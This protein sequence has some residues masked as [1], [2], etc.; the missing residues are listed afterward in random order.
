[1]RNPMKNLYS[2][3]AAAAVFFSLSGAMAADAPAAGAS[4]PQAKTPVVI[5][6]DVNKIMTESAAAKNVQ[7]QVADLRKSLKAEVDKKESGLRSE[8][9]ALAKQR[10]TLSSDDFAKKSR[11]FQESVMK[12]RQDVDA[13]VGALDKAVNMAMGKIEKQLQ[14]ILFDIAKEQSANLVLPKAAILVAETSM[15]FTDEAM[16]RINSKLP[17]VKVEVPVPATAPARK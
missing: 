6:I 16:T 8:D 4:K 9:E 10:G 11:S 17:S 13:R 2:A 1:M 5:V 3:L 14:S 15:D 12:S 7:S